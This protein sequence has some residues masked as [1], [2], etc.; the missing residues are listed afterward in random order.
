MFGYHL[1]KYMKRIVII[2]SIVIIA[3]IAF[4]LLFKNS[5]ENKNVS[6]DKQGGV[7]IEKVLPVRVSIIKSKPFDESIKLSGNLISNEE[8]E[9][10]SEITGKITAVAFKE[11]SY[12]EKGTLLV[13]I[14]DDELQAQKKKLMYK[15]K[16]ASDNELRQKTLLEKNGTS[17]EAYDI[18][19]NELQV[20]N[21]EL[22]LLNVQ[23]AKTEIRAPFSG[24]IGLRQVSIGAYVTPSIKIAFLQSINP[25]KA[26]FSIPQKHQSFFRSDMEI[27][28]YTQSGKNYKGRVFASESKLDANSRAL[29]V[30]ALI[31]NSDKQLIPGEFVVI[32]LP[33]TKNK[34]A[35][36]IP[37]MALVPDIKGETVY[38]FK[39]GIA[40]Q[41]VVTPGTR[42]SEEVEILTGISEGD[43]LII[44][45]IIQLRNKM[46][47][48]LKSE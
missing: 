31:S 39:N 45:G 47:V 22:E 25:I 5:G 30:R 26:E 41:T 48:K 35:I 36:M 12:V 40:A 11:G 18:A 38:L 37:S 33:M 1:D 6:L 24:T 10:R 19:F 3:I 13:K 16:L 7:R 23:L 8:V 27:D 15:I 17:K 9:I 44:S 29:V 28:V 14:N 20:L 32:S 43:T 46:P 4:V 2:V 42:T 34:N 21:S